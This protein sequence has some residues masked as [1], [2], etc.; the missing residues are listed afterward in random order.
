ML[1]RI[2][3]TTIEFGPLLR[4]QVVVEVFELVSQPL[5]DFALLFRRE[6]VDLL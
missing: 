1:Q 4:R 6:S 3:G 2:L 5:E